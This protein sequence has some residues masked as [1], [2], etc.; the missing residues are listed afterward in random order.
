[1]TT[2]PN[3]Q[4]LEDPTVLTV[5]LDG[6]SWPIPKLAPKQNEVVVPLVLSIVPKLTSSV[7]YLPLR[8]GETQRRT[9]MDLVKLGEALT[10]RGMKD[11]YTIIFHSLQRG[12]KGL[13]R[14]EFE[15]MPIGTLDAIEAVMTIAKQTG[16]IRTV[17]PGEKPQSGEA[18]AAA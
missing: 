18:Q 5:S 7:H 9:G 1:M 4:L 12:H 6:K 16:V 8:E 3:T 14:E 17:M 10:E 11:L 15:D 2:V 13:T